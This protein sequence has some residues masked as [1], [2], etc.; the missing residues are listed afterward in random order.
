MLPNMLQYTGQ[1]PT[2]KYYP[3]QNGNNAK[4]EKACFKQ[5]HPRDEEDISL[6][7]NNIYFINP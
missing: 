3:T 5:K 4:I 1:L 7:N 6:D 2:T